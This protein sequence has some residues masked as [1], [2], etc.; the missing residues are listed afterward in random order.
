MNEHDFYDN[1]TENPEKQINS[2]FTLTERKLFCNVCVI[3]VRNIVAERLCFHRRLS[4]C[5]QGERVCGR[6]TPG[7]DSVGRHPPGRH[8]V[9]RYP[10]ARHP[11]P[12]TSPG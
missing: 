7:R 3:T 12:D 1:E 10:L 9:G 2:V 11:W 8:P 6:H 5:S 4:F